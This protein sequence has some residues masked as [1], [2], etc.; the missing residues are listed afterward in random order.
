[1]TRHDVRVTDPALPAGGKS[2]VPA[3][4]IQPQYRLIPC[5]T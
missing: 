4:H 3:A 5:S 2:P 1:M